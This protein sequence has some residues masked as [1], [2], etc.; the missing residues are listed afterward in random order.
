MQRDKIGQVCEIAGRLPSRTIVEARAMLARHP[1]LRSLG[2]AISCCSG[3]FAMSRE[4]ARRSTSSCIAGN[5]GRST[6][7]SRSGSRD[8]AGRSGRG[9]LCRTSAA[10]W[11]VSACS[12]IRRR[13]SM[14]ART[15]IG[16]RAFLID[17]GSYLP[18]GRRGPERMQ[19]SPRL[20][21]SKLLI[22]SRRRNS[23]ASA[24]G[25]GCRGVH[26]LAS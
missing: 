8:A 1:W 17:L 19:L 6:L 20:R 5:N 13:A 14:R 3:V 16:K 10:A 15:P 4:E 9:P 25:P 24:G 11:S 7:L 22:I 2:E 26:R 12:A 23:T 18:T 21:V